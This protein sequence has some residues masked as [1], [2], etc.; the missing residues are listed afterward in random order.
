MVKIGGQ[1]SSM[2]KRVLLVLRPRETANAEHTR[3]NLELGDSVRCSGYFFSRKKR[4]LQLLTK[5]T[6]DKSKLLAS[7]VVN[8]SFT[9]EHPSSANITMS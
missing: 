7:V 8:L 9:R 1:L 3:A 2:E 6:C 5:D 4:G